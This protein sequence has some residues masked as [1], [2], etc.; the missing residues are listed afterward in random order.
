MTRAEK[1][2]VAGSQS[3]F[4][5]VEAYISEGRLNLRVKEEV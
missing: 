2:Q 1:Q 5:L 3:E 4:E